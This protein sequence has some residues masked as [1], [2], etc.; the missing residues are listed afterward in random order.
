MLQRTFASLRSDLGSELL[1]LFPQLWFILTRTLMSDDYSFL[2]TP[3][4]AHFVYLKNNTET[5]HQTLSYLFSI[6]YYF[7]NPW[8]WIKSFFKPSGFSFQPGGRRAQHACRRPLKSPPS[9]WEGGRGDGQEKLHLMGE[10]LKNLK[11]IKQRIISGFFRTIN[12]E[13][14]GFRKLLKT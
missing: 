9:L 10:Q 11:C 13:F 3:E 14:H 12:N 1:F 6:L 8:N 4:N 2:K 5:P 7:L